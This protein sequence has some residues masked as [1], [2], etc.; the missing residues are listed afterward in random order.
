MAAL[1]PNSCL[2]RRQRRQEHLQRERPERR[3]QHQ[4]APRSDA[5]PAGCSSR[6]A[7]ALPITMPGHEHQH[8]AEHDLERRLQERRVHVARADPGDRP[9]LDQH[10]RHRQRGRDPEVGDQVGQGVPD[11]AERGHQPADEAA[12]PG[13]AA[14]GDAAVVGERLGEAHRD[15]GADRGRHADQERVPAAAGG[16]GGGEQGRQRRDRA[17]HQPGEARLHVLQ[18]EGAVR[19]LAPRSRA[20]TRSGASPRAGAPWSHGRPRSR[21]GRPGA[22]GCRRR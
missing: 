16:E 17:V 11:P 10:H 2:D 3:R 21:R 14:A 12:H 6:G 22:C 7:Q 5:A 13:M 8:A 18:H 1:T 4:H 19:D 20:P 15:P 9:E